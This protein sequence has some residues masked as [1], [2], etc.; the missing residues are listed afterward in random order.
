M[1]QVAVEF[2]HMVSALHSHP[3]PSQ[4]WLSVGLAVA[5]LLVAAL[6]LTTAYGFWRHRANEHWLGVVALVKVVSFILELLS[7]H[8]GTAG[9]VTEV[10]CC[11]LLGMYALCCFGIVHRP[12]LLV[13]LET[14]LLIIGYGSS[15]YVVVQHLAFTAHAPIWAVLLAAVCDPLS[16]LVMLLLVLGCHMKE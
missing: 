8:D 3:S 16:T 4:I 13:P 1:E 10:V 5:H 7:Y 15:L 12:T 14:A 2:P 9:Q 6:L 11:A